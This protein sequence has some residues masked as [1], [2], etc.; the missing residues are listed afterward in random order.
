MF[1]RVCA[2]NDEENNRSILCLRLLESVPMRWDTIINI[3]F[4]FRY[5]V[6]VC[7]FNMVFFFIKMYRIG[8]LFWFNVA[9][10]YEP[11]RYT[12]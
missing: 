6:S 10:N 3:L 8:N 12:R 11:Q 9:R 4:I 1:V 5:C 7:V 2:C